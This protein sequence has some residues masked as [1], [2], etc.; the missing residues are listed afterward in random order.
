MEEKTDATV[1]ED[2]LKLRLLTE[3]IAALTYTVR[4]QN[5]VILVLLQNVNAQHGLKIP[6][7]KSKKEVEEELGSLLDS[8]AKKVDELYGQ[9]KTN[10]S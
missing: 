4:M 10:K 6:D 9:R 7:W 8:C 2:E 3:N 1:P 5:A